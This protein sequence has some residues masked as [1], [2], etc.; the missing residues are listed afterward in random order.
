MAIVGWVGEKFGSFKFFQYF[1]NKGQSRR[2]RS[3]LSQVIAVNE[4]FLAL[5][6]KR[7]D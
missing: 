3:V 4:R 7:V 1:I 6:V 5:C 2:N